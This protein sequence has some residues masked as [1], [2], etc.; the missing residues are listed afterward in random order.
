LGGING[1]LNSDADQLTASL[2]VHD[3]EWGTW[4]GEG[5]WNT[6]TNLGTFTVHSDS[7]QLTPDR[8]MSLPGV[9]KAI[10]QQLQAT[11]EITTELRVSRTAAD[12]AVQTRV[13][14][15]PKAASVRVA[16]IGLELENVNGSI[17]IDNAVVH[18]RGMRA[19]AANGS[20]EASGKLDF[21]PTPSV[22]QFHVA[23]N[24]LDLRRLPSSW[25]IP[26]KLEGYLKGSADIE[27][28]VGD[29]TV[30]TRGQGRGEVENARVAGIPA[31]RVELRLT[32][33]GRR[34]RFND[35]TSMMP[36]NILS[37]ICLQ[38][39][40]SPP[41][42]PT[43]EVKFDF[44]DVD[45]ADLVQRMELKIP[46]ALAGRVSLSAKAQLPL[47]QV[48]D[49][50][51]YRLTGKTN[52]SRLSIEHVDFEN[53]N[54]DLILRDGVLSLTNLVGTIPKLEISDMAAGTVSGQARAELFPL[55]DLSAEMS[56]ERLP[57]GIVARLLGM[58]LEGNRGMIGGVLKFHSP[59]ASLRD[60]QNWKASAELAS[61]R[62][63][64]FG[65]SANSVLLAATISEG[66]ARVTRFSAQ[67]DG[68]RLESDG[69][70]ELVQPFRYAGRLRVLPR[71]T[72]RLQ[73]LVP[74]A[75][76]PFEVNG[77]I[78]ASGDLRGTLS[79]L[80]IDAKGVGGA[81][82]LAVGPARID[83]LDFG[84]SADRERVG[85]RD[86]RA[87]VYEGA[88]RGSAEFPLAA[89]S[90]GRIDIDFDRIDTVDLARE[91][92]SMPV[93]LSGRANGRL[94]ARTSGPDRQWSADLEL[95]APH[96]RVSDIPT[97]QF[98]ATVR[99]RPKALEYEFTGEPA[100]GRL[101][102]VGTA[103]LD[104]P[105]PPEGELQLT[106]LDLARWSAEPS[107]MHGRID[108]HAK[109]RNMGGALTGQGQLEVR[110]LGR[111]DIETSDRLV[112]DLKIN[113]SV[114]T[115][116]GPNGGFAGGDIR[117]RGRYDLAGRERGYISINLTG[118]DSRRLFAPFPALSRN[119]TATFDG[120]L[121]GSLG[122]EFSG[123]GQLSFSRGRLFGL[124]V[125]DGRLPFDWAAARSGLG[126]VK[127]HEMS[128]QAGNGRITGDVEYA[129]GPE[130][131]TSG[132]LRFLRADLKAV[133]TETADFSS[134]SGKANGRFDFR[135]ENVRDVDDL[136]GT[137]AMEFTQPST[138]EAP[139]FR[140]IAPYIAPGQSLTG[141]TRGDL[142]AH[143]S[144]G[145]FRI[146]R[147]AL[148]APSARMMAD[149]SVSV[150]GRLDLSVAA[151][152]GQI[153][154]NSQLMR[155]GGITLPA[156]GPLP[157]ATIVR[158]SNS[159]SNHVVRLRVG[160]TIHSPTVQ[161]NAAA[162]LSESVLRYF[163]STSSLPLP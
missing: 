153:G 33:D 116:S 43:F 89:A 142:L 82:R 29:E 152:T 121:R 160:G 86:I 146:Q 12:Q 157:V 70:L 149:G 40:A 87:S 6:A 96:L 122:R 21:T 66:T 49:P 112:A 143:L 104:P 23:A 138:L 59:I 41:P 158:L 148:E 90:D 60:P 133:L 69:S 14:L 97:N 115:I 79:P 30:Q 156:V 72:A 71:G 108:L 106:G 4:S 3:P 68:A 17:E 55:K 159:L 74:E 100:G 139:F 27:L 93:R 117:T 58:A 26:P 63:D 101:R 120:Q 52:A 92:N 129:W 119:V 37:A 61:N 81:S 98:Q 126:E 1:N 56:I 80:S 48:S 83:R 130:S 64:V 141:F 132:Q 134:V 127:F 109:Y 123:T 102:W 95:S 45:L 35:A 15:T 103:P 54:A 36:M 46:L 5:T 110:S 113:Q 147:L 19:T 163:L 25:A 28:L 62:L 24:R 107:S 67:V 16:S 144:R 85:I 84:W 77:A 32:T 51:A 118:V 9:P 94:T 57:V 18:L 13:S 53:V 47:N 2:S 135:G 114:V 39:P 154:P 125:T 128:A 150:E 8:L 65:H 22:L 131:R 124:T 151:L 42:A 75:K 161:V 88:V 91:W 20:V 50:R 7:L 34:F 78:E 162:L 31:E 38:P 76:L 140:P 44:K 99:Y 137:L 105:G 10:W 111:G 155:L 145:V 73:T 11:G 136:S